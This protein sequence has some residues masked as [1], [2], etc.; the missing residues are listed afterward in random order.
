MAGTVGFLFFMPCIPAVG[1]VHVYQDIAAGRV[2]PRLRECSWNYMIVPT[3]SW[4]VNFH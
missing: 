4:M 2:V 1:P 3:S